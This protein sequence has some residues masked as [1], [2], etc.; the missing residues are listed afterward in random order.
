MIK[1]KWK[2]ILIIFS[3]WT[4]FIGNYAYA[5]DNS[6]HPV[7][8]I[9]SR[10]RGMPYEVF[11]SPYEACLYA[12]SDLD[13]AKHHQEVKIFLEWYL[14]RININDKNGMSGTIYD[15]ILYGENEKRLPQYD[16]IDGYSGLLLVLVNTYYEQTGDIDLIN[17][18]WRK[19][20]DIAYTISYLQQQDGLTIAMPDYPVKYLMD[21]CEAYGGIKSFLELAKKTDHLINYKY[22]RMVRDNIE[23]GVNTVL[24]N[25]S[26]GNFSWSDEEDGKISNWKIFYPDAYAQI[27]LVYYDLLDSSEKLIVWQNFVDYHEEDTWAELPSE[28][29]VFC[30]LVRNKM[31]MDQK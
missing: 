8:I 28:Q 16:S 17:R 30:K 23:N 19:L 3:I 24:F 10:Y 27:F 9:C 13:D 4:V 6:K 12:L 22:Y 21:N 14:S 20:E 25:K 7:R 5:Y 11:I 18:H 2:Y 26:V 1:K 15:V 29:A 31:R